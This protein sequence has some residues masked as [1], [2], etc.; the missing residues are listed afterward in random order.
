MDSSMDGFSKICEYSIIFSTNRFSH[1]VTNHRPK[2]KLVF[3]K[4]G[5]PPNHPSHYHFSIETVLGYPNDLGN[6]YVFRSTWKLADPGVQFHA[7]EVPKSLRQ[8]RQLSGPRGVE[9][10]SASSCRNTSTSTHTHI[11]MYIV[12]I[13]K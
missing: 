4:I 9:G 7:T 13:L 11:Y 5:V 10:S 8:R 3:P 12:I 1:P 6:L 2:K